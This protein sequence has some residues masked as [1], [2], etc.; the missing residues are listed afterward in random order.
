MK[1][2]T[3]ELAGMLSFGGFVPDA[4]VSDAVMH[5]GGRTMERI[6]YLCDLI[7]ASCDRPE[8]HERAAGSETVLATP[9]KLTE[10]QHDQ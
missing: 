10:C 8:I 4:A 5:D 2:L 1:M 3:L 6:G 9:S 7:N